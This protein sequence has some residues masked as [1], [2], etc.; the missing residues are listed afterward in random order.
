ME[1][2]YQGE[3]LA[4]LSSALLILPYIGSV[5]LPGK[6]DLMGRIDGN[7]KG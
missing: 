1:G 7:G 5:V 4:G 3:F 6:E 2:T